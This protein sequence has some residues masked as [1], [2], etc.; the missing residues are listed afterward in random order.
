MN[1]TQQSIGAWAR[2]TFPGGDDL[3]P[4]HVLRLLEEVV[5]ACDA[6]GAT[7]VE[8]IKTIMEHRP[9]DQC[10][11]SRYPQPEKV[12]E[13]LAD[14]QIVLFVVAERRG[15]NLQAEVDSKMATNRARSW[16]SNGDGTGY[17]R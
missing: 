10:S 15:I 6:A 11:G 2:A 8:I 5:E 9:D 4:R 12:A 14:C 3:S 13:E 7:W 16:A 1:E 17:H